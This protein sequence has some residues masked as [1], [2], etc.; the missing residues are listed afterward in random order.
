MVDLR[1]HLQAMLRLAED[2]RFAPQHLFSGTCPDQTQP[3]K[4]DRKC[5]ACQ[6][7][8][9]ASRALRE[10]DKEARGGNEA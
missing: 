4:R 8:I 7:M 2:R 10:A 9:A 5:P 3:G 6:A 1:P